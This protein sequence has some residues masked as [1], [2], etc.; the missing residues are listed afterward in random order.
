[1]IIRL[2]L[3]Y[4]HHFMEYIPLSNVHMNKVSTIFNQMTL[5]VSARSWIFEF[6]CPMRFLIDFTTSLAWLRVVVE[7]V[8]DLEVEGPVGPDERLARRA[9]DEHRLRHGGGG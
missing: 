3:S 5:T 9:V 6:L 8:A 2:F 1:M 4:L 7:D